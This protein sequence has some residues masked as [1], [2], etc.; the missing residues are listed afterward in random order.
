MSARTYPGVGRDRVRGRQQFRSHHRDGV[1]FEQ[2][3]AALRD[4]DWID[5]NQR[6]IE[7][8]IV[9]AA[10]TIAVTACDLPASTPRSLP[11]SIWARR[12]GWSACHHDARVF[13]R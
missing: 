12:G 3:I 10:S 1:S 6:Q 11:P 9:A 2:P 5:D 4:H 7:A 13:W 8:R